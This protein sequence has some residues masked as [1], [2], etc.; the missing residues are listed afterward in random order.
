MVLV[1]AGF[2]KTCDSKLVAA[3]PIIVLKVIFVRCGRTR[4]RGE[5]IFVFVG[6]VTVVSC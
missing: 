2:L 1:L 3:Y 4:C 5:N 6:L